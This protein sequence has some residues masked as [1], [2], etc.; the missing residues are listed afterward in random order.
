MSE[1]KEKRAA[2]AALKKAYRKKQKLSRPLIGYLSLPLLA[3]M[4]IACLISILGDKA[5]LNEKQEELELLRQQA[6]ALEAENSGYE[7]IL[8]E[9]DERTYMERIAMEQLGYAYPDERRFF[10]HA[11][12]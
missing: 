5:E 12:N 2:I 10:D 8:N 6:A 9:E 4:F 11:R 7:S 3:V 1:E